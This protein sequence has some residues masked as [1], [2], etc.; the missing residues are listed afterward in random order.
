MT[1]SE[2]IHKA[3]DRAKDYTERARMARRNDPSIAPIQAEF[4]EE[5]AEEQRQIKEWLKEL[6]ILRWRNRIDAD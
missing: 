4:Y 6:Q 2:A 3:D 5:C 1:L